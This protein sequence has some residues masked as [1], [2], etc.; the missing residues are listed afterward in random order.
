MRRSLQPRMAWLLP[1]AMSPCRAAVA[2]WR[3]LLPMLLATVLM[4]ACHSDQTLCLVFCP[5]LCRATLWPSTACACPPPPCS[6]SSTA[7]AART[8]LGAWTLWR[9][10]EQGSTV[11]QRGRSCSAAARE[12]VLYGR[13]RAVR[14]A[15]VCSSLLQRRACQLRLFPPTA[16]G[17]PA[18]K[19]N[20]PSWPQH[21]PRRLQVCGHEVAGRVR[22]PRRHHPAERSPRH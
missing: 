3:V 4:A 13:R 19:P 10:G 17:I 7:W 21:P 8:A 14:T 16:P 9:A 12:A 2:R 11:R 6:P 22:D 1:P 20:V 18:C 5:L 15:G